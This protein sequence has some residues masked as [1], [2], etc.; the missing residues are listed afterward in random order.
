MNAPTAAAAPFVATP[1]ERAPSLAS[2]LLSTPSGRVGVTLLLGALLIAILA[3]FISPFD[4]VAQSPADQL[5]PPSAQHWLGTD[6]LGRDVLSRTLHG[7]RAVLAVTIVA[8]TLAALIGS[9]AGLALGYIG[10]WL[11]D[12]VM[13]GVDALLAIPWTLVL[14]LAVAL[15]DND[16]R[17]L[18]VVMA[19]FYALPVIRIVRA[20]ALA[21]VSRDYVRAATIRGHSS[22]AIL[23][24]EIFPN[25]LDTILV[26][27]AMQ[28]SWMILGFS[29]LAFLGFGITPPTPDWGMMIGNNRTTFAIAPW[30]TLAPLAALSL[31]V[32][33]INLTADS[34][35]KSMGVDRATGG[36]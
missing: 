36:A 9:A 12:V 13:R 1:G 11:D 5:Q 15:V 26:E 33:G 32:I 28:W 14:L 23:A 6:A 4:P 2:K 16:L 7:G 27:G 30:A 31:L 29:S 20:A 3:P 10:G 22:P 35:A 19:I 21:Q 18:V 25:A 8:A 17:V 34:L 24:R